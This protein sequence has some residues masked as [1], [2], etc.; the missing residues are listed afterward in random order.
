MTI[1]ATKTIGVLL[2]DDHDLLR[3]GLAL[4]LHE[5][6]DLELLDKS[7]SGWDAINKCAMLKPDVVLMDILMP[8]IDGLS[9]ARIIMKQNPGIK[10]VV[11]SSFEDPD[12]VQSAYEI[13]VSGYL[14][15]N[16]SIDELANAV[17]AAYLGKR[18]SFSG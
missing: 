9:A 10:I 12:L 2:V 6:A 7:N 15:K 16:V 18:V 1:A 17:R 4:A 11:L 5:F 8:D 13:G 3:E 14:L